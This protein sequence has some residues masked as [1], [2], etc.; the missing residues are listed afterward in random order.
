M[1]TKGLH[2]KSVSTNAHSHAPYS[3]IHIHQPSPNPT[4]TSIQTTLL[5]AN[6]LI[7]MPTGRWVGWHGPSSMSLAL[8]ST[9]QGMEKD[10][11]DFCWING[12]IKQRAQNG[13]KVGTSEQMVLRVSHG[14]W[15][16]SAVG[17]IPSGFIPLGDPHGQGHTMGAHKCLSYK[18]YLCLRSIFRIGS[19]VCLFPINYPLCVTMGKF[20]MSEK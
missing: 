10:P 9:V 12:W 7:K 18:L 20:K 5:A 6:M 17:A 11:A 4:H 1:Y 15:T 8:A 3:H 16:G 2:R 19:T 13:P 14:K